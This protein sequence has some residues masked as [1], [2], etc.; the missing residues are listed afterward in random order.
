MVDESSNQLDIQPSTAHMIEVARR[1]LIVARHKESV[2]QA[3]QQIGD[4]LL[5][6]LDDLPNQS[7]ELIA[8][9]ATDTSLRDTELEEGLIE[10]TCLSCENGDLSA[11]DL[12][13]VLGGCYRHVQNQLK[14]FQGDKACPLEDLTSLRC[15]NLLK[16]SQAPAVGSF[17]TT[18]HISSTIFTKRQGE[19]CRK[20]LRLISMAQDANQLWQEASGEP[21]LSRDE[22]EPLESLPEQDRKRARA[23]LIQ[24]RIRNSFFKKVFLLYFDRDTLDPA[25]IFAHPTILDWLNAIA[26]TPHLFPFMQGQT[27]SQKLFRLRELWRKVLQ[28]NELYQRVD[29][30]KQRSD[31][32]E[33]LAEKTTQECMQRLAKDRFPAVKVDNDFSIAT[34]L[35]PF[36]EFA[37]WIQQK[38][39]DKDFVLPPDP[40]RSA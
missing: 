17:G 18:S 6:Q 2:E 39:M 32:R 10:H 5:D 25:E 23:R 15:G 13:Q 34:A 14:P 33:T 9:I 36:A 28:L 37:Q 16:I 3:L 20:S 12:I 8:T 38:V 40:K 30:A 19:R 35:S 29:Q 21:S 22:E 4:P 24:K 26:D 7:V 27:Q 11:D 1:P 31:Y